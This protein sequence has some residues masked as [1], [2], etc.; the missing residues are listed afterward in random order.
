MSV[1]NLDS[2]RHSP[3]VVVS[4]VRRLIDSHRTLVEPERRSQP[5][6][7]VVIPVNVQPVDSDFR[8][9]GDS[10][11]AFTKDISTGGIGLIHSES[12]GVKYLQIEIAAPSGEEMSLLAQ[13]KNC[14]LKGKCYHVGARFVVDWSSWRD[15]EA[16]NHSKK[17]GRRSTEG[18]EG[19][20]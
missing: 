17:M 19:R 10:F 14:T 18:G 9:A 3:E 15:N 8:P 12:V 2:A 13:V 16:A 11:S 6:E 7:A 1:S 5:R 20:V 4:F